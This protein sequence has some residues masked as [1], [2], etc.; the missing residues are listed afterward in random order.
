MGFWTGCF[1]INEMQMRWLQAQARLSICHSCKAPPC[2]VVSGEISMDTGDEGKS[3]NTAV[4]PVPICTG[5]VWGRHKESSVC[6]NL[7][8]THIS[9]NLSTHKSGQLSQFHVCKQIHVLYNMCSTCALQHMLVF[10]SFWLVNST[11]Y[12]KLKISI[13]N[14]LAQLLI[15]LEGFRYLLGKYTGTPL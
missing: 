7:R 9:H 12:E 5:S 4:S 13:S 1:T 6:R 14:F 2:V 10:S 11:G 8:H 3:I 15:K